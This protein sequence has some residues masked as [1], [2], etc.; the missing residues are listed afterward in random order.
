[1]TE[2]IHKPCESIKS[3]IEG[4]KI[5]KPYKYPTTS[6]RFRLLIRRKIHLC[7]KLKIQQRQ[8]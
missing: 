2:Q 7:Q 4:K 1:M 3:L 5:R 6:Y 8:I